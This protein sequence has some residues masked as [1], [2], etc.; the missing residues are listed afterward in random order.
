MRTRVEVYKETNEDW[1]PCYEIEG[2]SEMLV[3]VSFL[4]LGH[5]ST[6]WRVCVWGA[7][8][9]GMEKDFKKDEREQAWT[10]FQNVILLQYV[11]VRNLVDMGFVRA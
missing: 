4:S 5:D 2:I 11:N 8:D 6:E 3:R 7:D 10:C 1:Y 9:F